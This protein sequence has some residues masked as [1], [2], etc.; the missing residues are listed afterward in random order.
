[1]IEKIDI[2]TQYKLLQA[3]HENDGVSQR[4]LSRSLGYSLGKV[5]Y[6]MKG[7][8]EKGFVKLSNFSKSEHKMRYVYVLTPKG[9]SERVKIT[10]AYL[11]RREEE[12]EML[13]I[14]ID[15]IKKKVFE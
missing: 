7:L 9:I 6:L 8:V 4:E 11:K 1:M 13:R 5:N 15:D 3:I 10:G 12:Y 14:E 2:E